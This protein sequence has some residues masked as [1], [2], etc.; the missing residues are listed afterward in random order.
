M[1]ESKNSSGV[2]SFL[3]TV[4]WAALV[5]LVLVVIFM[6]QNSHDANL[7]IL[8]V[9]VRW[10]LWLA[11]GIVLVLSFAAGFL[12]RGRRDKRRRSRR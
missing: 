4:N 9:T 8:W 11:I 5:L 10:P 3:A 7:T 12:F 2:M 6:V 1:S